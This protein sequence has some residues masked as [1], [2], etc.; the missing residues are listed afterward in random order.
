MH[1]VT[2]CVKADEGGDVWFLMLK[3]VN[4]AL[5]RLF[6]ELPIK[7]LSTKGVLFEPLRARLGAVRQPRPEHRG[8]SAG[9]RAQKRRERGG[10]R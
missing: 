10:G 6:D 1:P 2:F 4:L 7:V 3:G 9:C 8:Q 5:R